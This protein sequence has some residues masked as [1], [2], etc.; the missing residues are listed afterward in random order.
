T[1]Y[2]MK[3]GLIEKK[4]ILIFEN[5]C[6]L[7]K[8]LQS[9]FSADYKV[10]YADNAV[11]A[12]EYLELDRY[13]RKIYLIVVDLDLS[14]DV[15]FTLLENIK[16]DTVYSEIP[17]IALSSDSSA[18]TELQA[19]RNGAMDFL[20]K[21][22]NSGMFAQQVENV[23]NVRTLTDSRFEKIVEKQK[24]YI[25]AELELR[26]NIDSLT[27]LL[28]KFSFYDQTEEML[29]KNL[30]KEFLLIRLNIE[31]FKV[32]NDIFG[33]SV[34]DLILVDVANAMKKIFSNKA[35][36]AR[37]VDDHFVAC[38]E[39]SSINPEYILHEIEREVQLH[40]FTYDVQIK[41]GIYPVDDKFLPVSQMCDRA[42]M[43]LQSIKGNYLKKIVEYDKK[44]REILLQEQELV[45]D[46]QLALSKGEFEIY[47]Q[48]IVSLLDEKIV[49]AE[50]L[51]R[52]NHPKRGMLA[53]GG[54]IPFFEKSGLIAKLDH[55]V[56][57]SVFK[58][59]KSRKDRNLPEIPISTNIS[60]MSLYNLH[61]A[62]EIVSLSEQYDVNPKLV[63]LEITES[64]YNDNP[65]QLL[66]TMKTL[67][68][69]GFLIL[70]D[71][72]GSGYS[73]LNMLKNVPVDILKIDMCFLQDFGKIQKSA[74]ILTSIVR[75][76]KWLKIP[77]VCEGVETRE[78][79][80]FLKEIGSDFVQGYFFS[81]P[82]SC[83]DFE[84]LE[85][86]SDTSQ[87]VLTPIFEDIKDFS[88]IFD[89][90]EFVSRLFNSIVGAVGFYEFNGDRLEVIRVNDNYYSMMGYTPETFHSNKTN[91]FE[92]IVPEN[93]Q[94]LLDTCKKACEGMLPEEIRIRRYL[95]DGTVIWLSM[96]VRYIGGSQGRSIVC[97]AMNNVTEQKVNEVRIQEQTF[98]L[99]SYIDFI[100][101]MMDA[102]PYG[103]CHF[104]I[105]K[106]E[107]LFANRSCYEMYGINHKSDYLSDK[108]V[109]ECNIFSLKDKD[110]YF[111][112]LEKVKE[113]G[114]S[115]QYSAE[116]IRKNGEIVPIK[117]EVSILRFHDGKEIFQDTFYDARKEASYK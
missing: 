1:F 48:P 52:W 27:G 40:A 10:L 94:L 37:L 111:K 44:L 115:E 19:L 14:D 81:K 16:I 38:F 114:K 65:Q 5:E 56:W 18:E 47:L 4:S 60:R 104:T 45:K 98:S 100:S 112:V 6:N 77:V 90:N 71:D 33:T 80:D 109:S 36:F 2:Y 75:M 41:M 3:S 86:S 57:E 35:V 51:V 83:N 101:K 24:G 59:Q 17:V 39:K 89:S 68:D 108:I 11:S 46:M 73:S 58:Y 97:C 85:L 93:R 96:I 67:Q 99:T 21:P 53:P 34:G 76:T 55:Y 64:A 15:G 43:A 63:K 61:L 82:V 102:I 9:L 117:G 91:I 103:I 69:K 74:N 12:L 84:K 7:G 26:A 87:K 28:N 50:A 49:S 116:I 20:V 62:D 95:S 25:D 106:K 113:T 29:K 88:M 31:R 13:S 22:F 78:Q 23:I 92:M 30:D 54:F 72:F 42:N 79:L 110:S 70:M 8:E 32:I 107:T 105:D 66:T